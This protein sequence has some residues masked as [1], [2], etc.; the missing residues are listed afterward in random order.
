MEFSCKASCTK[1]KVYAVKFV[2]INQTIIFYI[3]EDIQLRYGKPEYMCLVKT[4]SC[5]L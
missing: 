2:T 4:T 3:I 1:T 5:R